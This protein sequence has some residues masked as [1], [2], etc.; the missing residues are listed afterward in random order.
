MFF[1]PKIFLLWQGPKWGDHVIVEK[2]M[3]LRDF[4]AIIPAVVLIVILSLFHASIAKKV[5]DKKAKNV[6]V[7][8]V[9]QKVVK[10]EFLATTIGWELFEEFSK[11]LL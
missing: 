6:S 3:L 5:N 2:T 8:E 10:M 9:R 1:I 11:I 4:T 7:C